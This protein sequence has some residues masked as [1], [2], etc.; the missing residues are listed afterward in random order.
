MKQQTPNPA[1]M[2]DRRRERARRL[3]WVSV[4]ARQRDRAIARKMFR[5]IRHGQIDEAA[6]FVRDWEHTR[7]PYEYV[8]GMY[9]KYDSASG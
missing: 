7:Y 1:T 3:G 4:R 6:A 5:G 9:R 2:H 8:S